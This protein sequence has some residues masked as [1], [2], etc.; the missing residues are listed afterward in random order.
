MEQSE[1]MAI[2]DF[3]VREIGALHLQLTMA[4]QRIQELQREL[5]AQQQEDD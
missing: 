4:H 2:P 3:A 5:D 1:P